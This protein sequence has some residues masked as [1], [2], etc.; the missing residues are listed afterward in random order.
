[1][2]KIEGFKDLGLQLTDHMRMRKRK[3]EKVFNSSKQ[4]RMGSD[5]IN[6]GNTKL[7]DLH[8]DII[9][10]IFSRLP[11]DTLIRLRSVCKLWNK[12]IRDPEFIELH[13]RRLIHIPP[14]PVIIALA[15][16]FLDRRRSLFL[17]D[18][19]E[20]GDWRGR[21][22][23]VEYLLD[24]RLDLVGSCNGLVCMAPEQN[25]DSIFICNPI[26]GESLRL[27]ESNLADG[28]ISFG[29]RTAPRI[30]FGYDHSAKKYKVIRFWYNEGKL[31]GEII[32]L[33]ERSWRNLD[34]PVTNGGG[35]FGNYPTELF[36]NGFLY[37]IIKREGV[38]FRRG[39]EFILAFDICREKF[40][41]LDFP[42]PPLE[43]R[44]ELL[45]LIN[46]NGSFAIA[47]ENYGQS[48][49]YFGV[50]IS[51]IWRLVGSKDMGFSLE[52]CSS[53]DDISYHQAYGRLYVLL[54]DGT[55]LLKLRR[56]GRYVSF[57]SF[58]SKQ[59]YLTRKICFTHKNLSVPLMS[60][61]FLF[62]PSFVSLST[63]Y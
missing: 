45:Q 47:I 35:W 40:C 59:K 8:L 62:T 25:F 41:I 5:C 50:V 36:L 34:I 10:N 52:Q 31:A 4:R 15:T 57:A 42:W 9:F 51:K 28:F 44:Y 29:P 46:I 26:T 18:G 32:T 11:V 33:G 13:L 60:E 30:G 49:M 55:L 53:Y 6:G 2:K 24:N 37:W 3:R 14:S 54:G 56:W 21:E 48:Q 16:G 61:P 1:M 23:Q 38:E 58:H 22:I 27:P 7:A 20:E 39:D 43:T 19:I 63:T 17:V 12:L